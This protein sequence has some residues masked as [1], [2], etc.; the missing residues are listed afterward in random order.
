MSN[1]SVTAASRFVSGVASTNRSAPS[2]LNGCA[3]G[4]SNGRPDSAASRA[5]CLAM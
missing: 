3:G 4:T 1:S 2:G 5:D